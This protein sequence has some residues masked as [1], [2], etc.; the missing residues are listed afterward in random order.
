MARSSRVLALAL[1]YPGM[2]QL[3][4]VIEIAGSIPLFANAIDATPGRVNTWIY[5]TRKIPL[6]YI[7]RIVD[8]A[9][10]P[11]I[12]PETLRPDFRDGWRLLARQLNNRR[13]TDTAVLEGE[14]Q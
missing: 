13:R 12:T 8:F 4:K 7:P 11:T 14:P 2:E 10:D 5:S 9:D 3:L 1:S 6:E